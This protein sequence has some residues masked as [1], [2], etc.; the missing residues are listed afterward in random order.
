MQASQGG[1]VDVVNVLLKYGAK[2]NHKSN[3]RRRIIQ[4][5]RLVYIIS[6]LYMNCRA[7]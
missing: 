6:D 7:G 3:I 5:V 1:H 2:V 4:N